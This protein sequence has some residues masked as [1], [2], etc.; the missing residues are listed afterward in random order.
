MDASIPDTQ[1]SDSSPPRRPR[2]ILDDIFDARLSGNNDRAKSVYHDE[3]LW[4]QKPMDHESTLVFEIVDQVLSS[5]DSAIKTLLEYKVDGQTTIFEILI[6]WIRKTSVCDLEKLKL[7]FGTKRQDKKQKF[8]ESS[9]MVAQQI[10]KL[11]ELS[12]RENVQSLAGEICKLCCV[13][14]CE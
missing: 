3:Y 4:I 10:L 13:H 2:E 11:I 8:T 6:N 9:P 1:R 14:Q 12:T 5:T 7:V